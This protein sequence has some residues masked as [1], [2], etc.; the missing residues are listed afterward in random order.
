MGSTHP[1][2]DTNVF[3]NFD[4]H[5]QNRTQGHYIVIAILD[6]AP[7]NTTC[8]SVSI[9]E[10]SLIHQQPHLSICS[11]KVLTGTVY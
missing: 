3:V 7:A 10:N 5:L 9:Q 6:L 4:R 1:L 11:T 2:S 8:V